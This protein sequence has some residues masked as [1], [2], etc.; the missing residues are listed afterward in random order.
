MIINCG[1]LLT[2]AALILRSTDACSV[3]GALG[4]LQTRALLTA[5]PL[6]LLNSQDLN[7]MNYAVWETVQDHVYKNQIK[8]TA[9]LQQHTKEEWDSLDQ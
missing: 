8:D 5:S 7:P 4:A 9:E 6:W 2:G 3:N 1:V